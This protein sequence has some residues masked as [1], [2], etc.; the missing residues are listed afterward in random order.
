MG[1]V[2]VLG[3][4]IVG[5]A[6]ATALSRSG[7][8]VTIIER[9]DKVGQEV[10]ARNSCVVHAGLYYPKGSLKAQT[11]VLG[12]ERLYARCRSLGI[13][14]RKTGKLVVATREAEVRALESILDRGQQNGAGAL[15]IVDAAEVRRR[16]P[17][18]RALAALWSPE[19]GIVDVHELVK[20]YEAEADRLGATLVL[21]TRVDRLELRGGGWRVHTVSADGEAYAFD[22]P[23]VVNAAGLGALNLAKSTGIPAL[24]AGRRLYPCKGD[25]FS[26]APRLGVLTQHLV[27]PVPDAH[28]LGTH[29]T[30]DLG[31][32]FRLGPDT[33]YVS[34]PRYDVDPNKAERFAA[35]V[36]S[37][38]PEVTADLLSPDFAGVRPK[39][40]GPA[41]GFAD[42]VIEEGSA[43]GAPGLVNLLG[44][45][46]PGLTASAEIAERV[47]AMVGGHR[48][49][50][51][52]SCPRSL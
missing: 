9:N 23:V 45:E 48:R 22:S 12:R 11:C 35:A 34:T 40:Q 14:H 13:A 50:E 18:V 21:G 51:S 43:L 39:L 16:E 47:A 28:G 24:C 29:V 8:A 36:R 25:Y 6:A 19:T 5:L 2:A 33:E 10:T 1:D 49:Q 52:V 42:F 27:Y 44:I 32:R 38:L 37:Y 20:S 3:A 4:G 31:G 46:S 26:V 15:E 30:F 41:D 17:R 7:H